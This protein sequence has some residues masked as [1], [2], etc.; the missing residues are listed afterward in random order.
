MNKKFRLLGIILAISAVAM[1]ILPFCFDIFGWYG[2]SETVSVAISEN[3]NLTLICAKLEE[4]GVVFSQHALKLYYNLTKG[5][6]TIYPGTITVQKNSSYQEIVDAIT[7]PDTNTVRITIP[8]GYELGEIVNRLSDNHLITNQ[9]DFYQAMDEYTLILNDDVSVSG[10]DMLAGFLFPDTYDI[11]REASCTE[12]IQLMTSNFQTKWS[13]EHT[14]KAN[15]MDMSVQDVIILASIVEREAKNEEDFPIIAS[16][17]LNRLANNIPLESCATVQYILQERKPVLS[18]EDTKID[19]PYNTYQN[20][21]LP[22]APISAPGM[23]AI[24]A[25][26]NPADTD[27]LYFFTDQNGINHYS[28][29]Y[30]EHNAL[31]AQFGL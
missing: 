31:I 24:D 7:N 17:F 23:T 15:N 3:D 18:A 1:V 2:S 26:L 29:T 19:S 21:G 4:N 13:E 22:P 20:R 11:R 6:V 9:E 10:K 5:N 8:E 27:Y 30:E 12:I 25:V 28:K 14:E 16:V